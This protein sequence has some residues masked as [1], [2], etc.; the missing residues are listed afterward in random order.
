L[1]ETS[2]TQWIRPLVVSVYNF[3]DFAKAS[4]A[5]TTDQKVRQIHCIT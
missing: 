2:P 4:P 3:Y 1:D 5:L